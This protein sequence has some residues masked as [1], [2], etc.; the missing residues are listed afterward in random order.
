MELYNVLEAD[1]N[2][3]LFASLEDLSLLETKNADA[4][5]ELLEADPLLK[6]LD[7]DQQKEFYKFASSC[8][9]LAARIGAEVSVA[10]HPSNQES[11]VVIVAEQLLTVGVLKAYFE[12]AVSLS[13]QFAAEPVEE[14]GKKVMLYFNHSFL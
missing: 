2:R 1:Y 6:T 5:K 12:T 3:S 9:S 7:E 11:S 13:F 4:L 10:I 8:N 14:N